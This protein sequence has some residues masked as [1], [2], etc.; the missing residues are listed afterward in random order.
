MSTSQLRP[1]LPLACAE[2]LDIPQCV[3]SADEAIALLREH[4]AKW[5]G[6]NMKG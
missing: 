2:D 3:A 6:A 5:Q 4:H 1:D